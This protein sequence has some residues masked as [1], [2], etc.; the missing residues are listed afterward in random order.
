MGNDFG[1]PDAIYGSRRTRH[2]GRPHSGYRF[3]EDAPRYPEPPRGPMPWWGA[4][5]WAVMLLGGIA[6]TGWGITSLAIWLM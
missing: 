1:R 6:F 3:I 2:A 5:L 4:L